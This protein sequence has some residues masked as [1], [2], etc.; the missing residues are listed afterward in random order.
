MMLADGQQFSTGLT[1]DPMSDEGAG[2][3]SPLREEPAIPCFTAGTMIA[4]PRGEVKVEDLKAGD[5]VLTR[6]NGI[7]TITWAGAKRIDPKTMKRNPA[8][9]PILIKAGALGNGLPDRDLRLS[10]T[11]RVLVVSELA[12]LYFGE[13]EVLVAA[14][15]LLTMNDVSIAKAPYETYY[16][17]MCARHELV[18]SDG[19]WTESFQPGDYSLKGLD[20]DQRSE[21]FMLFPELETQE[22]VQAFGTARRTL[23]RGEVAL[24]INA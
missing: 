24:L 22:G 10:P 21:L 4:T 2:R 17:F 6:D 18:L 23:R 16:H 19:A 11:H 8:L 13:T 1:Y 9:R 7:Q 5:R 15:H 14:K 20:D 12:Q 3:T